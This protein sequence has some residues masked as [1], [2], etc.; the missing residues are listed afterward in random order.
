[1]SRRRHSRFV[2]FRSSYSS[3]RLSSKNIFVFLHFL[4]LQMFFKTIF[5]FLFFLE[6]CL[7]RRLSSLKIVFLEDLLPRCIFLYQVFFVLPIKSFFV[8]VLPYSLIDFINIFP[9]KYMYMH[10]SSSSEGTKSEGLK[11]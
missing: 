1:M 11:D 7:P 3:S 9:I 8:F 4:F 2:F 5:H 6:D 10:C